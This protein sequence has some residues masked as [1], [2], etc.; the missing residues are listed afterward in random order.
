MVDTGK[1]EGL[2][3]FNIECPI[4]NIEVK[5]KGQRISGGARAQISHKARE[6]F[7]VCRFTFAVCRF[8][9]FTAPPLGGWGVFS[10]WPTTAI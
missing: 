6:S 5:G 7:H 9:I 8:T 10:S 1:A 3:I 2:L 4:L